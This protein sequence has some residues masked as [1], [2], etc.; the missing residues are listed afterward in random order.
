MISRFRHLPRLPLLLLALCLLSA[1][2]SSGSYVWCLGNDGEAAFKIPRADD[3]CPEDAPVQETTVSPSTSLCVQGMCADSQC[4]DLSSHPHWRSPRS[5]SFIAKSILPPPAPLLA[6][7]S[8]TAPLS[9]PLSGH[10]NLSASPRIPEPI[11]LHRTIV[12][13]I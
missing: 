13:L 5:R 2:A 1:P 4:L 8:V 9:P 6:L 3:C 11:L 12:L 7:A 10:L